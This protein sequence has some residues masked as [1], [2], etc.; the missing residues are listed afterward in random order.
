MDKV[1]IFLRKNYIGLMV[2]F[3]VGFIYIL[4]QFMFMASLGDKYRGIHMFATPNE[5]AYMAIMQEILDGHP[6]V[7]SMPFFEYKDKIPLLPATLFRLYVMPVQIFGVSLVN[8]VLIFKFIL[9]MI[10]F[11]VIYLFLYDLLNKEDETQEKW[12]IFFAVTGGIMVLFGFDLIIYE[13]II[14]YLKGQVSPQGFLIWA[15]PINPVSGAI[16]LFFFLYCLNKLNLQKQKKWIVWSGLSLALMMAS[17]VFSWTLAVVILGLFGFYFLYKKNWQNIFNYAGILFLGILF[18]LPYWINNVRAAKME[19]YDEA[20]ARIGMYFTHAPHV[21]KFVLASIFLFLII[22]GFAY[23]K[24]ILKKPFPYWWQVSV[25]LL[26]SSFI[27][28]NQQIITGVE[29]WYYHYVFYTISICYLVAV[30][31][32]WH[33]IH[34]LYPRFAKFGSIMLIVMSLSLGMFQHFSAYKNRFAEFVKV[35]EYQ[36]V[37]DFFNNAEKDCVVLARETSKTKWSNLLVAFTHCNTYFSSE[38]QSVLTNPDD[39]YFRYLS[40]LRIKGV[41]PEDIEDY[42]VQ[43]KKEVSNALQYQLQYTLGM[44]DLKFEKRLSEMPGDY[45]EFMKKD[46]YTELTKFRI[47][48]VLSEGVL[49]EKMLKDLPNLREMYNKNNIFIYQFF[50]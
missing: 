38:N 14:A 25:I 32:L 43:N 35:Q 3:A 11:F 2:A 8:S 20:A 49:D 44:P 7:A 40:L 15:R 42:V 16:L 22:S 19:W 17:Y 30:L 48:Y 39:F 1:I 31:S 24:K 21:N 18:S 47:D 46:F 36:D 12:R 50:K 4:P 41:K 23:Y 33:L 9:P 29:I 13:T 37:F 28:Y 27:V 26:A 6:K 34:P 45:R 5:E 10:L